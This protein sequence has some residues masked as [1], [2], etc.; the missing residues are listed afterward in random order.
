MP[1]NKNLFE[2]TFWFF[3]KLEDK[4]RGRLS[5]HPVLY[6]AIGGVAIVLFWKGV[7]ETAELFP[8][9]FGPVS[10]IVSVATLLITGLFVSF[11]IGDRIILSGIKGEKKLVEKTEKEIEEEEGEIEELDADIHRIEKEIHALGR[12]SRAKKIKKKAK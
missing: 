3:D 4:V 8:F 6:T 10:I 1:K 5:R 11:F 7:W 2:K 9:L 12:K